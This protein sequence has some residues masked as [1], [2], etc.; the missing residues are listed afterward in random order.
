MPIYNLQQLRDSAPAEFRD[1]PAEDLVRKYSQ[2]AGVPFS[3]AADFFGIAP[4]G[5]LGEVGRQLVGGALVDLPKMV[6]QG[7]QYTG[8]A[9]ETGRELVQGAEARAPQYA[10]DLRG[11]GLVGEARPR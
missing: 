7:L 4:R 3:Q 8:I 11:R 2:T 6:G 10:P 5:T 1:L 9:P